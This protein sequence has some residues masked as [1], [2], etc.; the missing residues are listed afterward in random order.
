MDRKR[1]F[2]RSNS[3][4]LINV[5]G[6]DAGA[7]RRVGVLY[8]LHVSPSGIPPA[9]PAP[10]DRPALLP[11]REVWEEISEIESGSFESLLW[12]LPNSS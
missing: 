9:C 8:R 7:I 12:S 4:I 5:G 6:V 10:P 11:H 3:Y 1:G 2:R